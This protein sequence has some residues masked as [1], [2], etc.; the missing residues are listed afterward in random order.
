MTRQ[1]GDLYTFRWHGW[2]DDTMEKG[3]I[4]QANGVDAFTFTFDGNGNEVT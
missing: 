3:T 1:E 2:P 4:L